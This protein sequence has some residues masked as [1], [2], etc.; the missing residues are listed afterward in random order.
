MARL[1]EGLCGGILREVAERHGAGIVELSVMPDHIHA[2]VLIPPTMAVSRAFNLLKG[3]S[4]YELFRRQPI[5]VK[6]PE[7]TLLES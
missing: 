3:T 5:W 2:I 1:K 4:S 6:V 7:R